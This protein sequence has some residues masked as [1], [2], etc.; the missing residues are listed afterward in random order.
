MRF[1]I[2]TGQKI[3]P[4]DLHHGHKPRTE[5]T[6]L[7]KTEKSILSNWSEMSISANS[8]PK[9][10]IYVT[11]N[12][13]GEVSNHM[14]MAR[15]KAEEKVLAKKSPEK[16]SASNYPFR[17]FGKNHNKKSLEGMFQKHLQTAVKSTEHIVTTDTGTKF[18]E[19]SFWIRLYFRKKEKQ[20]Q[21]SETQ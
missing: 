12:E 16:N 17:F 21:R 7:V 1:T 19:N 9:I 11:T 10:P 3:T 18:T 5:L 13:D 15:T 20:H 4:F 8:R 14:V 2:H 6:N